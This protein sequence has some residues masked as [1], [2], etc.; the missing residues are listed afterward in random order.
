LGSQ[1]DVTSQPPRAAIVS[2]SSP[3]YACGASYT[4]EVGAIAATAAVA[5]ILVRNDRLF[6]VLSL[7]IVI[8]IPNYSS[9]Y[10]KGSTKSQAFFYHS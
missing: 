4:S 9:N 10:N 1:Y 7:W 8:G 5:N 6:I 3:F 2:S